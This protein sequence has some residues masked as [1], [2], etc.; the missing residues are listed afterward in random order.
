MSACHVITFVQLDVD[1]WVWGGKPRNLYITSGN[2][3]GFFLQG[4]NQ[5]CTKWQGDKSHLTPT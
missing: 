5:K 3:Q 2:L 4:V 1:Y